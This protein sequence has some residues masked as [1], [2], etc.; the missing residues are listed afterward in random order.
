MTPTLRDY[1]TEARFQINTLLNA[2]RHPVF[3]A[4]TGTGKTKTATV[5][6]ADRLSLGRRVFVLTPQVEIFD[7]WRRELVAAG[8]NPGT[9]D[10][11]GIQGRARGVYVVM[12]QTLVN[13]LPYLPE[14]FYPD[15]IITDECHHS[16]ADTWETIYRFF[17]RALRLGLTA[18]PRRTDGKPLN[19][20]GVGYTDIVQTITMRQAIDRHFLA[21]PL[22]I[23]P[24]IYLGKIAIKNGDYDPEEQ[25]AALGKTQIVGNVIEN[26]TLTFGGLPV[27]VAC[28]TFDHAKDMAEAFTAA[29]WKFEHIHSGLSAVDRARMIRDIRTGKLNGLCTVG[30]GIEGMDIPGLYGLI[31][32]RRTLSLTIYLQ[33]IGRALRAAKG[34]KYGVIL[35]PVGNLFI[36]G[37]P[38]ADRAWGLDSF[39]PEGLAGIDAD[40]SSRAATMRICPF[41]GVMSAA[42]NTTCHFCGRNLDDEAAR[43]ARARH[44][45]AMVDGELVAVESD[46]QAEAIRERAG[47]IREEQAD[48]REQEA[49]A[50][51]Q[52]EEAEM[53]PG[54]KAHFLREG[55]LTNRRKIFSE[56]VREFL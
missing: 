42:V 37:F 10:G 4:P 16:A 18:T 50:A 12:P 43:S 34:K 11:K 17:P 14:A 5:I 1:Q 31:W 29:G 55:L 54:G 2:S 56:A 40:G 3:V 44:L 38:E 48:L 23:V 6:I 20:P 15:E 7:Q 36:H 33:F 47:K 28:S 30:I 46:G 25:A 13:L 35:D 45:P 9:I 32:L 51:M 49:A 8:L 53:S 24:E 19:R 22:P 52:A 27:L 26:Y 39:T 41:C 21:R